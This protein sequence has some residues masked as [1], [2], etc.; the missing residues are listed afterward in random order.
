[1]AIY[2]VFIFIFLI[3]PSNQ[4]SFICIGWH[5]LTLTTQ[6]LTIRPLGNTDGLQAEIPSKPEGV[7][8]LV[9]SF[10]LS[11]FEHRTFC[12][13]H[14]AEHIS[15]TLTSRDFLKLQVAALCSSASCYLESSMKLS[16]LVSDIKPQP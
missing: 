12:C 16:A 9:F 8:L 6:L 15:T 7:H 4:L 1:M 14:T 11:L 10:M 2:I 3:K 5:F 13:S